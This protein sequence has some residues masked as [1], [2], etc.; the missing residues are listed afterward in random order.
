MKAEVD[1]LDVNKLVNVPTS[2]NILKTNVDTVGIEV[3]K[4]TKFDTMKTKRNKLDR[5]IPDGTTLIH[6][7]Q[8]NTDKPNLQKRKWRC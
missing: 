8:Q 4:N 2:L 6:I 3:A 1:E 5:K 7:N